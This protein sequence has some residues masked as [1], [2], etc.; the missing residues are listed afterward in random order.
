MNSKTIANLAFNLFA[1]VTAYVISMWM[2]NNMIIAIIMAAL[3]VRRL[4]NEEKQ[5]TE[6]ERIDAIEKANQQK[7]W[8]AKLTEP[9]KAEDIP[10]M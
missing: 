7:Q 1:G 4:R 3:I 9:I 10:Q 5:R 2:F 6:A 8:E